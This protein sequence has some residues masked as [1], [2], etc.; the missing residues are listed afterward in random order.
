VICEFHRAVEAIAPQRY[1]M[2]STLRQRIENT[3]DTL[4]EPPIFGE[5]IIGRTGTMTL[6]RL[7]TYFPRYH[8]RSWAA[9]VCEVNPVAA[10]IYGFLANAAYWDNN[11]LYELIE[12][13]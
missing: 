11:T 1:E 2:I 8:L 10:A 3:M 4:F 13:Q 9:S 5:A 12:R 6:H 7:V